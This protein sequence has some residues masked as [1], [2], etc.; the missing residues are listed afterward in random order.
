MS[1][2]SSYLPYDNLHVIRIDGLSPDKIK[3][4]A[5]KIK[6]DR[7]KIKHTS[8]LNY[9]AKS[10]GVKGGISGYQTAY[11]ERILPFMQKHG[12]T[13]HSDLF[14][15]RKPGF[16]CL[17]LKLSRQE[18]SERL[19]VSGYDIP[20]RVYT[21]YDFNY[22]DTIDDTTHSFH[23][24]L[25]HLGEVVPNISARNTISKNIIAAQIFGDQTLFSIGEA[26]KRTLRDILLGGYF[27]E[28]YDGFNLIG[29]VLVSPRIN[30]NISTYYCMDESDSDF[31]DSRNQRCDILDYFRKRIE[32]QDDGWVS[33]IPFNESL[34]FIKGKYGEYDVLFK[35]QRNRSFEHE[36]FENKLK[37]ADVPYFIEDYDFNRWMYFKNRQWIT[38]DRHE[39]E[40]HYYM[41]GGK[42]NVYPGENSILRSYYKQHKRYS[43]RQNRQAKSNT[44]PASFHQVTLCGH[45]VMVSNP[46]S[47]QEFFEFLKDRPDYL[48]YR[49]GDNVI[50]VNADPDVSLPVSCTWFDALAYCNWLHK[51]RNLQVRLLA[52][53]EY[54]E[55][56][57]LSGPVTPKSSHTIMP[58]NSSEPVEIPKFDYR[59]DLVYSDSRGDYEGHPPYMNQ[60]DDL[61]LRFKDDLKFLTEDNK[62]SFIDSNDF[63]EWTSER[64]CIRSGNLRNIDGYEPIK[65]Q[66]PLDSTGKYKHLKVGF[67]L[68]LDI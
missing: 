21:G 4:S 14:T 5:K 56:R 60:F 26:K 53:D 24:T 40:R 31:L 55:L 10:L 8:V 9:V 32:D 15:V 22:E 49:S 2:T 36:V 64:S 12:L 61:K 33:V 45:D 54:K 38:R 39:S 29:D 27:W 1:T 62:I 3:Q 16:D 59:K 42:A 51:T 18:L 19:F 20:E 52:V 30:T 28:I 34:I 46:I 11:A 13:K 17:L 44:P 66:L 37:I 50:N 57:L 6:R 58:V 47:I 67:R 25:D 65:A 63:A 48:S 23:R 68:C 43:G 7:E 41:N 35:H